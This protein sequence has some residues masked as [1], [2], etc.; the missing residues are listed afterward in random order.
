M[1]FFLREVGAPAE[2]MCLGGSL[3]FPEDFGKEMA[4]G[5]AP[6]F[7]KA[8]IW[9]AEKVRTEMTWGRAGPCLTPG[10][11]GRTSIIG[12]SLMNVFDFPPDFFSGVS[13]EVTAVRAA[14]VSD[15][16][17]HPTKAGTNQGNER[18]PGRDRLPGIVFIRVATPPAS[19]VV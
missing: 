17:R 16:L 6:N 5:E 12:A 15:N 19:I 1:F 4:R 14:R 2:V 18:S 8:P 11:Q 7:L 9:A 10:D 3:G 13:P